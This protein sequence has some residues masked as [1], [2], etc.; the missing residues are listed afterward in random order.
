ML[1]QQLI[2]Q[3]NISPLSNDLNT[4]FTESEIDTCNKRINISWNK[5]SSA[6]PVKVTGYDVL[7]S[8][9]GGTY[10]LAGHVS[11]DITSFALENF[12]NGTQYCFI[13]KAILE[14]SLASASNK[15]C[16]VVNTQNIP[17]WINAD[18]ATVSAAGEISLSFSIDPLSEIDLFTLERKSGYS[19]SFQ[20]DCTDKN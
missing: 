14:N 7:A 5:Y 11:D 1:L 2:A 18:F 9:N 20:Q 15:P 17:Q 10:Y 16:V 4:I 19:G 8:V 12:I 3:R 6:P 13:V